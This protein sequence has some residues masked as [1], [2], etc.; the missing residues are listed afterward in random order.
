MYCSHCGAN[1]P[2]GSL[3]CPNCGTSF[4]SG[5]QIPNTA[6]NQNTNYYQNNGYNPNS[7]VVMDPNFDYTPIS[8]WG[9]IGYSLLF[10]IPLIGFILM[11][12]YACGGTKN[13]NLRNLSRAYLIGA[14]F[15]VIIY[16]VMFAVIGVSLSSPDLF[17]RF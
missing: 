5:N 10:S 3:A 12:V 11:I 15:A 14:C 7:N 16:I 2:D 4:G 8:A 13:I 9:Y 1:I 6:Q 17:R